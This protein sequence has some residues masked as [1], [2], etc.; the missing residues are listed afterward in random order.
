MITVTLVLNFAR[1]HFRILF[2]LSGGSGQ[3]IRN[4][5]LTYK[6]FSISKNI[7]DKSVTGKGIR[8][9]IM[10]K[11][12]CS[13]G[14]KTQFPLISL[15]IQLKTVINV[16]RFG[17]PVKYVTISSLNLK[18]SSSNLKRLS[19]LSR[20]WIV[21]WAYFKF[22][23]KCSTSIFIPPVTVCVATEFRLIDDTG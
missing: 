13:N 23:N 8:N 10:H 9:R 7:L 16:E 3:C 6:M 4:L 14:D 17:N 20:S 5:S 21:A 22:L 2:C 1:N 19:L 15:L 12:I 18:K 11:I